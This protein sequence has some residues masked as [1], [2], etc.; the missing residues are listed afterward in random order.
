[1]E[2]HFKNMNRL[3]HDKEAYEPIE[4]TTKHIQTK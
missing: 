3:K 2:T 4:T 1:M